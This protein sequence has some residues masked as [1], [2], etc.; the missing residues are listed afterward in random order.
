M[1]P[2]EAPIV[3]H[4]SPA[5]KSWY[6]LGCYSST[7]L[8]RRIEKA[9][10]RYPEDRI[11][12]VSK[13]RPSTTSI[14]QIMRAAELVASALWAL[15]VRAGD[16]VAIQIPNWREGYLLTWPAFASVPLSSPSSSRMRMPRSASLLRI[17]E[18]GSFSALRPFGDVVTSTGRLLSSVTA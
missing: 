6:E 17:P 5:G 2:S 13:E 11:T 3:R 12:F 7:T 14:R 15:G 9:A 10:A 18:P 4:G 16:R 8:D 1:R